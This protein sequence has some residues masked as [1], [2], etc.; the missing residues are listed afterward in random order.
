M[1]EVVIVDGVR[2]P[3]GKMGGALSSVRPDDLLAETYK[4]LIER[5]GIDPALL[6]EVY[7]GCGNQ[8]GEGDDRAGAHDP[9]VGDE[10]EFLQEER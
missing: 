6:T 7:A 2:T 4:A 3:I 1:T 5:T 9:K 10:H 8:G